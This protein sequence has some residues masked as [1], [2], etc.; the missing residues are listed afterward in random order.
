LQPIIDFQK[1]I[2][3]SLIRSHS[4]YANKSPEVSWLAVSVELSKV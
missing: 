3:V 4:V 1:T 2:L